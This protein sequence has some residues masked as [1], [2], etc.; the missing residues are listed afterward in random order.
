MLINIRVKTAGKRRDILQPTAYVIPDDI[1]TLRQFL[2]DIVSTEVDRYNQKEMDAQMIP[3]LTPQHIEDQASVGKVSF[4]TVFSDKKVN[5]SKA[6]DNAIQCWCDGFVRVFM[7]DT[8]LIELDAPLSI[9]EGA[10]FTLIRLI[11]L[12]GRMW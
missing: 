10:E 7:N 6:V 8:E 12:A 5:K 11:F 1:T 4:G 2:A 9:Q 3:F